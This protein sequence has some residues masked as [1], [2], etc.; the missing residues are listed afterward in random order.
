MAIITVRHEAL[1]Q[2]NGD[3]AAPLS[4]REENK[5]LGQQAGLVARKLSFSFF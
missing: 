3:W 4:S 1:S 2:R 5:F